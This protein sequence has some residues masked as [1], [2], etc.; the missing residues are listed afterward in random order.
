M[1][2][3]IVSK[4]TFVN[5]QVERLRKDNK[6]AQHVVINE[7]GEKTIYRWTKNLILNGQNLCSIRFLRFNVPRY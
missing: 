5:I 3:T 4:E 1:S 6:L 7:K 2:F